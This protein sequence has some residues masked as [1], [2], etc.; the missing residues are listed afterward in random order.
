MVPKRSSDKVWQSVLMIAPAT[1]L[2]LALFA[3]IPPP[4]ASDV[5]IGRGLF[6]GKGQCLS[7]HRI[8]DNGKGT[9]RDL[10]WIGLLRTPEKLRAEVTNTAR[11]PAASALTTADVDALVLPRS[12][13]GA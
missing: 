2:A 4:A 9:A 3:Q 12:G 13:V 11:H 6:E 1:M 5:E 7:C 10:A 8:G